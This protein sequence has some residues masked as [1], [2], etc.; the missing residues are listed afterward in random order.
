[1]EDTIS[2]KIESIR[3]VLQEQDKAIVQE[4]VMKK[5]HSTDPSIY[6]IYI[7]YPKYDKKNCYYQEFWKVYVLNEIIIS[8]IK[9]YSVGNKILLKDVQELEDAEK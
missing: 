1:L 2:L 8:K 6:H 5:S 4:I 3:S 9:D 7:V